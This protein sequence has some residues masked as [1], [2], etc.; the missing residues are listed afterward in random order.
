[1]EDDAVLVLGIAMLKCI[2]QNLM[3]KAVLVIIFL[4]RVGYVNET[5]RAKD[6][7]IGVDCRSFPCFET[8]EL[9]V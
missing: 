7:S 4:D 1:V 8:T 3:R 5:K 9:K 2:S 6:L